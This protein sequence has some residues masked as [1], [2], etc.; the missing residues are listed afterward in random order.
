MKRKS[1]A[2]LKYYILAL[3]LSGML[4]ICRHGEKVYSTSKKEEKLVKFFVFNF[5]ECYLPGMIQIILKLVLLCN[6]IT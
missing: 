5:P 1:K 3:M 6:K 4:S 2:F